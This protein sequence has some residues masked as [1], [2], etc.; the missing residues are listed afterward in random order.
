M[1]EWSIG[2]DGFHEPL[3][4]GMLGVSDSMAARSLMTANFT[5]ERN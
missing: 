4:G 5:I 3:G 2:G 1:D